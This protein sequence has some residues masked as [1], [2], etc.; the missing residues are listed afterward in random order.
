MSPSVFDPRLESVTVAKTRLSDIDGE[1]GALQVA[2]YPIED[3]ATEA[4]YEEALYLLLHD[5]LPTA[6]ELATFEGELAVSRA[7]GDDL[8]ALLRAAAD[9]GLSAM[10]ALQVGTAAAKLDSE[11][12]TA[13]AAARRVVAV[14][15]TIVATYWRYRQ[16]EEPVEP[17]S[18][19]GH[20]ANYLYMLTGNEP[21]EPAV[22]A[23]ETFLVTAIDHG[24]NPSTFTARTVVSTE[25]D[26]VSAAA[27]A[28]GAMKGRRHGGVFGPTYDAL[29]A[30][31][32]SGDP[33][34]YVHDRLDA[35]EGVPGFGHRLYQVRDPRAAVMAAAAERFYEGVDDFYAT[36]EAFEATATD[37][38]ADREPDRHARPTLEFY[39]VALLHGLDIPS[40]LFTA[41]FAISRV[42][43]WMAHCLEQQ[44]DDSLIRPV[45]RY[46]GAKD[47][48]WTPIEQRD[49]DTD[50]AVGQPLQSAS[51]ER[52]A[53]TLATLSEPSRLEILLALSSADSAVEYSTLHEATSIEDKGRF[54]YHLRQLREFF[55]TKEAEKYVLTDAGDQLVR[56]I[57]SEDQLLDRE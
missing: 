30:V 33:E 6:E 10:D 36:V 35:G 9:G 7:I 2:G 18:D 51:L 53:E 14:V 13:T 37:I 57:V 25:S 3:L 15:P 55:V 46:V 23:L 47:R 38:L 27:A 24:L 54:N 45:S 22:H 28:A 1:A 17:R 21:A 32:D 43:G 8:S 16:G 31:H 34:A 19:L 41:T 12:S 42:G 26:L 5:R 29:R 20:A 49:G 56:T 4:T 44:A 52:V 11:P 39:A 40:E 48:T 50:A